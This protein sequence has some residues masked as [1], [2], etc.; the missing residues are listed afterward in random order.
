MSAVEPMHFE[1][2]VCHAR[3]ADPQL[4]A[5]TATLAAISTALHVGLDQVHR[6]LCFAHRRQIEDVAKTIAEGA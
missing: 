5:A 3:A 1:C 6:D 4:N 2:I